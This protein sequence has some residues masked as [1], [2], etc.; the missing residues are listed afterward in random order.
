MADTPAPTPPETPPAMTAEELAVI[1]QGTPTPPDPTAGTPTPPSES[2]PPESSTLP[3]QPDGSVPEST[4]SPPAQKSPV[5]RRIDQLVAEKHAARQAAAEANRRAALAES[6]M[7][8]LRALAPPDGT[9][10][11]DGTA[12]GPRTYT[13]AD[14]AREAARA[15]QE[16]E[17]NKACNAAVTAGRAAHPETFDKAVDALRSV[18][19]V[20]PQMFVEAALET[21]H[22]PEVLHA[23]GQNLAEYDRIISLPPL[24]QAVELTKLAATF[25]K[26]AESAPVVPRAKPAPPAPIAPRVGGGNGS[27]KLDVSPD[28]PKSDEI[29]SAE[30]FKRREAQIAA[31]QKASGRRR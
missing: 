8:E 25:E 1:A 20:L 15:A 17:F 4:P 3:A 6:A 11:E 23:L 2:T 7:A 31:A 26:S 9:P 29:P 30:W 27:A 19:P 5:E 21:G 18:T 12:P 13:E 22:A 16:I 10:P 14:L 24:R 28:D